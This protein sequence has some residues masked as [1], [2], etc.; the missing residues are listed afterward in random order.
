MLIQ[1]LQNL[2]EQYLGRYELTKQKYNEIIF[3]FLNN[4]QISTP[5][6]VIPSPAPAPFSNRPLQRPIELLTIPADDIAKHL[7][8]S[9]FEYFRNIKWSDLITSRARYII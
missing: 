1:E 8:I 2:L 6:L 7:C 3:N 4:Y 5:K 9:Q